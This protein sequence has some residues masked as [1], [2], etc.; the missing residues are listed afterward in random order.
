MDEYKAAFLL[1]IM[2]F[3]DMIARPSMGLF[4]NSRWIRPKIQYFFSFAIL[5]NGICHILCPVAETYT[6]LA[7]YTGIF[8]FTFG[9]VSCVL[10]ETLMDQVGAQRFSSAVGLTTIVECFPVLLGPPLLGK[11]VD[12]TGSYKSMYISCGAIVIFASI[13]LFIGNF[14]NY[15]LLERERKQPEATIELVET[16]NVDHDT[17]GQS[18]VDTESQT[19]EV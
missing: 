16:E 6:G 4:A 10:F 15:R 11:L 9:M 17:Q 1:S 18:E 13:W 8:G 3:T 19:S 5:L 12:A 14:I 7:I 2:A